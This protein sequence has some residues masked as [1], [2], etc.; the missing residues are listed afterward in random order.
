MK[1]KIAAYADATQEETIQLIRDLCAIPAPSHHEER[2]A[3]FCK[4]WFLNNGFSNI[5]IDEALNVI[6]PVNVKA[7]EPLTVIM[8]HT[9]TVFPDMDPLPIVEKDGFIYSPGV[10]DDTANLAVMMVGARF[11]KENL[12]A[13]AGSY[14][15]VANSCEEGLGNLKGCRKIMEKYGSRV[16]EFISLDSSCMNRI[17]TLAV[18][19]HRYKVTVRTEG[20]HSFSSFGNRNAI[21]VLS[22]MI[23]VLYSIKVPVEGNSK[24]SYNVGLISG[25]TS[26]NT[27]AQDAEMMYE[28]RS[29][30]RIC[31]AKMEHFFNQVI[32]TFRAGDIDVTVEKVGDR[33][34]S[35]DIDEEK[36]ALLKNRIHSSMLETL[37][38]AGFEASSSTDCNVPL[39]MGIP[40]ICFGVCRGG[41]AHTREEFLETASLS[42]GCRLFLDFLF[43][44]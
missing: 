20:G 16:K 11:F 44:K 32:E 30:N 10:T 19:S 25:G 35:G 28:Y 31:L 29:D 21:H 1:E 3:E 39:S 6:A 18:G 33:P 27:I 23:N 38:D 15:F 2:R 42:D 9:D 26:V 14:L 12:P 13:D 34:C 37:G 5:E 41:K 40:A 17:V 36:Y 4:L 24:T 7:D 22:N 43:R 8:A